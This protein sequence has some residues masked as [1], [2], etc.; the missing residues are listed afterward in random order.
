MKKTLKDCDDLSKKLTESK[1]DSYQK[2]KQYIIDHPKTIVSNKRKSREYEEDDEEEEEPGLKRRSSISS[3]D[4]DY[5]S[6]SDDDKFIE[7]EGLRDAL[8]KMKIG[9]ILNDD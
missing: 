2:E 6:S 7:E 4:S 1:I 8:D 9:N 5:I 3:N